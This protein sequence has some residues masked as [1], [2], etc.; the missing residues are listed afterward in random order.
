MAASD[1][2]PV[3]PSSQMSVFSG[4]HEPSAPQTTTT[5]RTNKLRE[6]ENSHKTSVKE[7]GKALQWEGRKGGEARPKVMMVVEGGWGEEGSCEGNLSVCLLGPRGYRK[8]GEVNLV[9]FFFVF[10]HTCLCVLGGRGRIRCVKFTRCFIH[11]GG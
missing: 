1:S 11:I 4:K 9:Y 6:S 3:L 8:G 2:H 7:V 10:S 5:P